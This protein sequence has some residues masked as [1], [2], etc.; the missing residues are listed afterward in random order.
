MDKKKLNQLLI[1]FSLGVMVL[2]I[3]A[4]LNFG[5]PK[6]LNPPKQQNVKYIP[7]NL[8]GNITNKTDQYYVD[9]VVSK[10]LN[11]SRFNITNKTEIVNINNY[12]FTV[13]LNSNNISEFLNYL[14]ENNAKIENIKR[15]VLIKVNYLN[16]TKLAFGYL[17]LNKTNENTINLTCAVKFVDKV[18]VEIVQCALK[19]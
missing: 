15:K 17:P 5:G 11:L 7:I 2:S 19:S 3:L 8:V 14:K 10:E 12:D 9:F 6:E 16:N 18:P 1:F 13:Y 4:Y